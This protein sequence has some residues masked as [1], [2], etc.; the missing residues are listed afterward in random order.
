MAESHPVQ[1]DQLERVVA[2]LQDL[3]FIARVHS[4][5]VGRQCVRVVLPGGAEALWDA[6]GAAGLEAQVMRNGILVGYCPQ[7]PGS[8]DFTDEQI[9]WAIARAEYVGG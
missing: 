4:L 9:I 5:G 8:A 7:V 3:G 1:P 6:D 2:G